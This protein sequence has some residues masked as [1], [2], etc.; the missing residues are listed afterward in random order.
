MGRASNRK[1]AKRAARAV[2]SSRFRI[3]VCTYPH[4]S[5]APSTEL[6]KAAV[7]YADE[8]L[9][10]S[11]TALMLA[12]VAG[13][14]QMSPSELV[15]F[16]R[17]AAPNLGE[18]GQHLIASLAKLESTYGQETALT[19]ISDLLDP[20][21]N[22]RKLIASVDP[23]GELRLE[24]LAKGLEPTLAELQRVTEEQL[25]TRGVEEILPAVESGVLRL[26]PIDDGDAD[27]F[28]SYLE[29]LWAVLDDPNYHP[30]VDD[31]IG[32]LVHA[33]VT[34]RTFTPSPTAMA[35]GRQVG[36]GKSFLARLPTFPN[37]SM[38]EIVDIRRE[39]TRP[40]V[41]FRAEMVKLSANLDVDAF[42]PA[43]E[44]EL[45]QAWIATVA[46][47]LL[48][49]EEAVQERRLMSLFAHKAGHG[50]LVGAG[51]GLVAALI[52]GSPLA[53]AGTGIGTTA[54]STGLAA[55]ADRATRTRTLRK[56]PY[57]F[58]HRTEA[59]LRT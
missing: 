19:F 32:E 48:E 39:L 46:P 50:G 12:A 21:S 14:G 42:D 34:S 23:L 35:R 49:L 26:A 33:A 36:A 47:A 10:H 24:A 27:F 22:V 38:A 43:F 56:H 57:Y 44:Q 15:T 41:R 9:F 6:L 1:R 52:T 18:N 3:V 7:I 17:Q 28:N 54:A 13:V 8:V 37:A 30:L 25:T 2:D 59:M 20:G 11:P 53:V 4:D 40:L 5:L 16:S 31:G 55:L 58:L 45:E 29:K 51:G